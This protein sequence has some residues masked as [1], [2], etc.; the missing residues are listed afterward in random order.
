MMTETGTGTRKI[1]PAAATAFA[2]RTGNDSFGKLPD[3]QKKSLLYADDF[4]IYNTTDNI[5]LG[6][7]FEL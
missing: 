4:R 7:Q 5:I 6:W 3:G 2:E 1:T